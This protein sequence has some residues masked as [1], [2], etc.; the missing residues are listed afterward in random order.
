MYIVIKEKTINIFKV[1]IFR[2]LPL[3]IHNISLYKFCFESHIR[4]NSL[5]Q[6]TSSFKVQVVQGSTF[7]NILTTMITLK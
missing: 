3:L 1:K 2:L 4:L 7:G 6:G 5:E